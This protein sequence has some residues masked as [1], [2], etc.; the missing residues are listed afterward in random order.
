MVIKVEDE[1]KEKSLWKKL[2]LKTKLIVIGALGSFVFTVI[3]LVVLIA[4][5]MEL[6]II[7]ISDIGSSGGSLSYSSINDNLSYWWPI[8]SSETEVENDVVYAKG[9]PEYTYVSS[10][11]GYREE[12]YPGEHGGIDIA[13]GETWGKGNIIAAKDGTVIYPTEDDPI[14]CPSSSDVSDTCGGGYGNY[15]MIDHGNGMVTLYGHMYE[16]SITVKAGDTVKQGQ[17]IGL[18]GSSGQSNGSHLHFEVRNN[19]TRVDPQNYV[20]AENPRPTGKYN[21]SGIEGGYGTAEENKSAMCKMLINAGF[22]NNA[23][24]GILVNVSHEGGFRTNNMENCYEFDRC[25]MING[26]EY[27]FCTK[28][29]DDPLR[30]Y[31]NDELY[32]AAID[33]GNYTEDNFSNDRVGY[34]LIQWTS[35]GRKRGLYK[36]SKNEGKSIADLSLQVNYLFDELG[37]GSYAVTMEAITDETASAVEIATTF[38]LNFERPANKEVGCPNRANADAQ[39]YLNYVENGCQ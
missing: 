21:L 8:G 16:N 23:V 38:C 5:L 10:A 13:S 39:T 34:G 19:G 32:T 2:P 9:N 27:G 14:N 26:R 20:S 30:N 12:P 1:S 6:G 11:F 3:F 25:C 33:S 37:S 24:A 15:V 22:S 36:S 28:S 4:P 29:S 18:M 35:S 31:A 17:V 7:D